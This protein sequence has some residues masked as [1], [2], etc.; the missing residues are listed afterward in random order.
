MITSVAGECS[1]FAGLWALLWAAAK[2]KAWADLDDTSSEQFNLAP[3]MVADCVFGLSA[4]ELHWLQAGVAHS[5]PRAAMVANSSDAVDVQ[6]FVKT[7]IGKTITLDVAVSDT[8][9]AAKAKIEEQTALP[10]KHQRLVFV[11]K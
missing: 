6:V 11:G 7:L 5:E 2:G 4:K 1:S 9:A 10:V 3:S 8:V